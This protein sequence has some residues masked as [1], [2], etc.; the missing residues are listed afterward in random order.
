MLQTLPILLPR[1]G[2][3]GGSSSE[4]SLPKEHVAAEVVS[5]TRPFGLLETPSLFQ[6]C[7][8]ASQIRRLS[9]AAPHDGISWGSEADICSLIKF[10]LTDISTALKLPLSIN[11]ELAITL[12]RP[13]F[14]FFGFPSLLLMLYQWNRLT[15]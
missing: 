4:S 2:A 12:L 11:Q 7:E 13:G 9:Q 3:R 6:P 1:L 14:F 8:V 5:P 10:V 15:S